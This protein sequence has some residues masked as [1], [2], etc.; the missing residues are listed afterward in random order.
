MRACLNGVEEN[1]VSSE[2]DG[3]AKQRSKNAAKG[4]HDISICCPS[5]T[6]VAVFVTWRDD[7]S[8]PE[9]Y[10][11]SSAQVTPMTSLVR[12]LFVAWETI[13]EL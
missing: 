1:G 9:L 6:R 3:L 11:Q 12:S 2:M 4:C 7:L 8:M 13:S 10:P 5:T